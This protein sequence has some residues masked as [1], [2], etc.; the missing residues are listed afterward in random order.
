[1][2]VNTHQIYI[3]KL[4][5]EKDIKTHILHFIEGFHSFFVV[6]LMLNLFDLI[7][8]IIRLSEGEKI[9]FFT[10]R[11][12]TEI[13]SFLFGWLI[14][15]SACYAANY[16]R[17]NLLSF[18]LKIMIPKIHTYELH[19]LY[20]LYICSGIGIKQLPII[21]ESTRVIG[22]NINEYLYIY[23]INKNISRICS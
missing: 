1:M 6:Y 22:S 4:C 2:I 10:Y 12:K 19:C 13:V 3:E 16:F 9:N 23:I 14:F 20:V 5:S 17:K 7:D 18:F 21:P 11:S 15:I 8:M